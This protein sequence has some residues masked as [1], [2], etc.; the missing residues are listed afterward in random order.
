MELTSSRGVAVVS[1]MTAEFFQATHVPAAVRRDATVWV[2]GQTGTRPDGSVA[3]TTSE[4][5]RQT[6]V[7]VGDCLEAAGASWADVVQ[8]N[9]YSVGLRQQGESLLEIAA[10]FLDPPF[11]AWTAVGVVELWEEGAEF[12]LECVAVVTREGT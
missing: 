11:P 6:F 1:E 2:T 12:E 9:S 4:Q 5:I 7:N 10:E 3:A 8:M